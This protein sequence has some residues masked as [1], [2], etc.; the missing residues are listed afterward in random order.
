V[1]RVPG[2][3]RAGHS[4][5]ADPAILTDAMAA[6]SGSIPAYPGRKLKPVTRAGGAY[7]ELER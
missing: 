1:S 3:D 2:G 5:H 7:F 6:F 4:Y